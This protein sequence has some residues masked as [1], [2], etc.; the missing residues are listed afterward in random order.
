M[1]V[2]VSPE[3]LP[4]VVFPSTTK[5][6]STV[7]PLTSSTVTFL[8]PVLTSIDCPFA[9]AAENVNVVPEIL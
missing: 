1:T 2:I 7:N 3:A 5:L 8:E 6:P 4:N 9:G